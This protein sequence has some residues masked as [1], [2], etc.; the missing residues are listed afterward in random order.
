[1]SYVKRVRRRAKCRSPSTTLI[2]A[3]TR[4]HLKPGREVWSPRSRRVKP[5]PQYQQKAHKRPPHRHLRPKRNSLHIKNP[6]AHRHSMRN[7]S[8]DLHYLCVVPSQLIKVGTV[9][10]SDKYVPQA[11]RYGEPILSPEQRRS[12]SSFGIS[13]LCVQI[14]NRALRESRRIST[15]RPSPLLCGSSQS[16]R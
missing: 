11:V 6:L 8:R 14:P 7:S 12:P 13:V 2:G 4:I 1:M 9:L 10:L 5:K 16:R 15:L 3:Q